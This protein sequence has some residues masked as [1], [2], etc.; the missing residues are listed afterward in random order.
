MRILQLSSA[1]TYGGGERHL[2]DLC[3]ELK[4]RGHE[5]F[6]ALR[7]T[8]EWQSRLDFVLLRTFFM[9]SIRNS[10]GMFSAK[11][12]GRFLTKNKIDIIHAHVARDYIRREHRQPDRSEYKNSLDPSRTLPNEAISPTRS[13]K[14]GCGDRCF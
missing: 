3:R 13:A 5:I 6:V 2:V 10:F 12:I 8:N 7:P 4:E 9:F 14:C 1:K 11:R